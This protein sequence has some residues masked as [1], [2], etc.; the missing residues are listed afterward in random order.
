MTSGEN[1]N[2]PH[3]Q[4]KA[5][6]CIWAEPR[7]SLRLH[8]GLDLKGGCHDFQYFNH[9]SSWHWDW[10]KNILKKYLKNFQ[11]ILSIFFS[12]LKFYNLILLQFGIADNQILPRFGVPDKQILLHFGVPTTTLVAQAWLGGYIHWAVVGATEMD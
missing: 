11:I 4:L 5:Q 7:P 6:T 8:L 10:W 2:I 9:K 12:A 3:V 1:M